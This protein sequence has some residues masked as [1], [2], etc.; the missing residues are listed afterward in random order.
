MNWALVK[1]PVTF[2]LYNLLGVISG[3]FDQKD[4][5]LNVYEKTK[6]YDSCWTMSQKWV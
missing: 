3:K 6:Q 5:Y 4:R 1:D 2:Y